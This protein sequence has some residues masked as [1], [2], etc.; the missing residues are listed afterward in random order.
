MPLSEQEQRLLEEMERSLYHND[1]DFVA[2]GARRHGRP[3]YA[4]IVTG[5]LV[6][7]VGV[8]TLIAGVGIR[9]PVVGVLGFVLMFA[10]VLLTLTPPRR[11]SA[12]RS[13]ATPESD[14]KPGTK[15][16]SFLQNL[17]DRWDNR[18]DDTDE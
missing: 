10:G 3:T 13:A 18:P 9:V 1:A 12:P 16:G 5:V 17:G 8:A 7:I 4:M 11:G 6:G 15:G 14:A 2:G